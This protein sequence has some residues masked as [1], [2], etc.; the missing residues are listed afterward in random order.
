[1][2]LQAILNQLLRSGGDALGNLDQLRRSPDAGKYATGAAVGG[3]LGLL[4]GS[5]RGRSIGGKA[6]KVGTMVALGS[7][8][9]KAYQDYQAQQQAAQGSGTAT[10]APPTTGAPRFE[11]LPPPQMEDHAGAMLRAMIAAAKCDGHM[12]ARERA[13]IDEGLQR[14][15]V[16]PAARAWFDAEM[17]KPVDPA[18]IAALANSPEMASELY[19]ASALV[20]DETTTMERA[21]LDQLGQR[22]NLPSEL[23][24][25]LEQRAKAG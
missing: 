22:L 1:M 19:L 3:V 7:L 15:G 13:L 21:Y 9:W 25:Q 24:A 6:V 5:R 17:N 10:P 16:D 14:S 8:A 18:E 12:D 11:A 4:L 20:V 2:N 23:R